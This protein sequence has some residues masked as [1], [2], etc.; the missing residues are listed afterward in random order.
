MP[1]ALPA[2]SK[3]LGCVAAN[4]ASFS[5]SKARRFDRD[6]ILSNISIIIRISERILT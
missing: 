6:K 3:S 5:Y 1:A 4:S 2:A